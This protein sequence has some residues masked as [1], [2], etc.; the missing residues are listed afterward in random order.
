MLLADEMNSLNLTI[1]TQ[2]HILEPQWNPSIE[3]QA[4]GRALRLTQKNAVTV[5]RYIT[6]DTIEEV[7]LI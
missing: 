6:K 4:I 7:R 1:A 5:T 2:V 3:S